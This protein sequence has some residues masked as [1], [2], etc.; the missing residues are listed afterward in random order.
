MGSAAYL[1]NNEREIERKREIESEKKKSEGEKDRMN[2][3]FL[4]KRQEQDDLVQYYQNET[5][6]KRE[7]L[8]R[9]KL[10]SIRKEQEGQERFRSLESENQ[11]VTRERD[12]INREND[13]LRILRNHQETTI[14]DLQNEREAII[15]RGREETTRALERLR[16]EQ[17]ARIRQLE[18]QG[19][20]PEDMRNERM[21]EQDDRIVELYEKI[22]KYKKL[23]REATLPI[24]NSFLCPIM[25]TPMVDPVSTVDGF[26]YERIGI[27]THIRHAQNN[28][29]VPVRSPITNSP[30]RSLELKP[31][32]VLRDAIQDWLQAQQRLQEVSEEAAEQRRRRKNS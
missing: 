32:R 4:E 19:D 31:E 13:G 5:K 1:Y 9:L 26:V 22:E 17:D 18:S 11:R 3:T 6:K 29:D 30:L 21:R 15:A 14:E 10:D 8:D 25:L 20:F 23:V 27:E 24:P 28:G 7:E 2:K 12:Q 16:Q